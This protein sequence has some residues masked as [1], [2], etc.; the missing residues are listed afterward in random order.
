[1]YIPSLCS[2]W[3]SSPSSSIYLIVATL[4]WTILD[5][6]LKSVLLITSWLKSSWR[7][8]SIACF[9]L[10][11]LRLIISKFIKSWPVLLSSIL[12]VFLLISFITFMSMSSI[13]CSTFSTM[14][15]LLTF[16]LVASKTAFSFFKLTDCPLGTIAIVNANLLFNFN[17]WL[18]FLEVRT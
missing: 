14:R 18:I 4:S 11:V 12:T 3:S 17:F 8:Y 10:V 9:F 16:L 2:I 13:N 6:L 5:F 1:M 15:L 7:V